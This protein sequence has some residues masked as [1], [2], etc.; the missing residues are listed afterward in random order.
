MT[1][2]FPYLTRI[3]SFVK[4][5]ACYALN[6]FI[7]MKILLSTGVGYLTHSLPEIEKLALQLGY[8]GVE[9]VMPP[10]HLSAS[11]TLRDTSYDGLSHAVTLHSPGDIYD[12]R[13]FHS[14]LDDACGV[15]QIAGATK[16]VVHPASLRYGGRANVIEA[17]EYIKQKQRETNLTIAY[18]VLLD[19]AG[20]AP[21]RQE[22]FR[23]MQAY[24][25]LEDWL[26]DVKQY[27][28]AACLDTAHIGT[29]QRDPAEL[30]EQLGPNLAHVHF[31]DYNKTTQTEHLVPG[32]GNV[33]L[34]PFLRALA[35]THPDITLTQELQ[36]P[37]TVQAV[38]NAAR[39]SIKFIKEALGEV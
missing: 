35:N 26:A 15:A 22:S 6:R 38:E 1:R 30:L 2:S 27:D 31:G 23:E 5:R 37:T 14:A 20:L 36:P 21:E 11:E 17:I 39:Q 8:D 25:S 16:V 7:N 3:F 19:P 33:A 13:R 9:I 18:E 24:I 4:P 12:Q 10:R 32:T 34:A 28:L 29:W